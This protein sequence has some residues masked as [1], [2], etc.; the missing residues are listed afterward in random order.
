MS[1][2]QL[3]WVAM[4]VKKRIGVLN[5]MWQRAEKLHRTAT[6]EKYERE[7]VYIYGRLRETWE[8]ALEEVLLGGGVERFRNSVESQRV[9]HLSD[10]T[11][12]D[13]SALGE[14]MTKSSRWLAG[15][16]QAAAENVSVP[17]P[18]ELQEDISALEVWV[19]RINRRR[20]SR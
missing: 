14:G 12:E 16:D 19:S 5:D 7:A 4:S 1:S 10:I 18:D 6:R 2:S 15:H 8:R 11:D 17:N 13:C 20:K 3:P 9:R